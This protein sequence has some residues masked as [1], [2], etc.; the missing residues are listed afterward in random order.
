MLFGL[1][2][3]GCPHNG[4]SY[5]VRV[6]S[7]GSGGAFAFYQD[8][9]G[10][11]LYVQKI[12]ADGKLLWGEKGV[13]LGESDGKAYSYSMLNIFSDNS[14]GAIVAWPDLAEKQFRPASH[15]ARVDAE[16]DIL[17]QRGFIY[18][19]Q[20]IS[21]SSG[22]VILAFDYNTDISGIDNKDL[23]L[24]RVDA[25]GDYPWS[26][27]GVSVPRGEYKDSTLQ[28]APDGSG[29]MVAVWKE[30]HYPAGAAPGEAKAADSLFAR[31]ISADGKFLWGE[32]S[33]AGMKVLD[34]PKNIWI[35]SLK[36]VE[37]SDG[38]VIMTWFQVTEDPTAEAGH[39]QTWDVVVQKI[40]A[41]GNILRQPGGTPFEITK[42]DPI[43]A[44]M[45]PSLAGDGAGGAI[46]IW[47][48]M[49][50]DA[51]GEASIYAQR[52]DEHGNLLWQAGGVK[53]AS[54]SLNPRP[55]IVSDGAGGAIVS[56]SFQEDGKMLHVQKLDSSGRTA[57][58]ENGVS[59]T[60][61]GFSSHYISSD[62]QG[63][64]VISWGIGKGTFSP[65]KAYLQ[66][67]SADG[68]LLWGENGIRL[69]N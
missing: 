39:R 38:G 8:K 63:G 52:A 7:D 40:D 6:I 46:V 25:Q 20:I 50:R 18:F 11:S 22:G 54:T 27:Q 16:G 9:S 10:G 62:G 36:A 69:N 21:D 31:R 49:R 5:G 47:R 55:M 56:Y 26:L 3:T 53:V 65:E 33:G 57:W 41:D 2:L 37:D 28:M 59:I 51:D 35:D 17:W 61:S 15:L 34:F 1:L 13:L 42:A 24:V 45:E 68:R 4:S 66:R 29:G 64:I 44:P 48:D 32:E 19:E 58:Q 43:A 23:L 14:G 12:S 30:S 60:E 67:V